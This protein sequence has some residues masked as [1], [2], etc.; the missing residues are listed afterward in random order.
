MI[1]SETPVASKQMR[2]FR[3][4][5]CRAEIRLTNRTSS[6][7]ISV[8]C[9]RRWRYAW[10]IVRINWFA[11]DKNFIRTTRQR[12]ISYAVTISIWACWPHRSQPVWII[13]TFWDRAQSSRFTRGWL[14]CIIIIITLTV[15][16][17]TCQLLIN[18]FMS[19]ELAPQSSIAVCRPEK[20]HRVKPS[21]RHTTSSIHG[22]LRNSCSAIY[23][24]HGQSLRW[25][26]WQPWVC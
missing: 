22:Q 17:F 21:A 5:I 26:V 4:S 11:A 9:D 3:T 12:R 2:N 25:C 10:K 18:R 1:R 20:M 6:S 16:L 13:S 23:T 24:R 15:G 8:N 19:P 14:R 7:S